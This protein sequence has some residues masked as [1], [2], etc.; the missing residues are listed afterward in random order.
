MNRRA[1]LVLLLVACGEQQPTP[2]PTAA[3]SPLPAPPTVEAPAA[4]PA[5]A[6]SAELGRSALA[7]LPS[8]AARAAQARAEAAAEAGDHALA[9]DA[10]TETLALA[11][12]FDAGRFARARALSRT[13]DLEAAERELRVAL[14]HDL[15]RFRAIWLEHDDFAALRASARGP[16]IAAFVAELERQWARA[17]EIGVPALEWRATAPATPSGSMLGG[18][19]THAA[20]AALWVQAWRRYVLVSPPRRRAV[21]THV[22][23]AGQRAIV[24]TARA[25]EVTDVGYYLE[26]AQV[27]AYGLDP[28][29]T[30][31]GAWGAGN[32]WLVRL[33]LGSRDAVRACA[34]TLW[35]EQ[36]RCFELRDG[37]SSP[38]RVSAEA[39]DLGV[40]IEGSAG[41]RA[42][43]PSGWSIEGARVRGPGFE[44]ELP[45][46]PRGWD[47][48]IAG[49]PGGRLAA[50]VRC[51]CPPR[52]ESPEYARC[53]VDAVDA[54]AQRATRVADRIHGAAVAFDAEGALYLQSRPGG[55]ERDVMPT[56]E[57]LATPG[58]EREALPEG[59]LLDRPAERP[60]WV[61]GP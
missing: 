5:A 59:L 45:P 24:V 49:A 36:D 40:K 44:V 23:A 56:V 7:A 43:A 29:A 12:D 50:V 1:L 53:V 14:A 32:T 20:R 37:S 19:E 31:L 10:W 51:G 2:A 16:E 61:G 35:E 4:P 38:T 18:V 57:R 28:S 13:G 58:G 54:D 34:E 39:A 48:V 42:T 15:A 22:D 11:P 17:L 9:R 3:R 60:C 33:H 47:A 25:G 55:S 46:T 52:G 26:H 21:L 6:P 41:P 30:L 8:R 27:E